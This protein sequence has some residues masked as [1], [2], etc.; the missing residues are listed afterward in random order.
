VFGGRAT[1]LGGAFGAAADASGG[2]DS[3]GA[4]CTA[5]VG[6]DSFSADTQVQLAD[7]DMW[8]LTVP[9]DHDFYSRPGA[10][11]DPRR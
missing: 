6:G 5:M 7:G 3:A 8:D 2:G 10:Q 11:A 9:G 4:G 1:V